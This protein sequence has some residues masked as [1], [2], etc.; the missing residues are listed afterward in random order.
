MP[1][2]ENLCR[3]R[4]PKGEFG[5]YLVAM[6]QQT[7]PANAPA[8][9]RI[10]QAMD[11]PARGHQLGGGCCRRTQGSHEDRRSA[12]S[13]ADPDLTVQV[14]F[15]NLLEAPAMQAGPSFIFGHT[16]QE[17]AMPFRPAL[18]I[19]LA[20]RRSLTGAACYR[21]G[22]GRPEAPNWLGLRRGGLQ[23]Y[24]PETSADVLAASGPVRTIWPIAAGQAMLAGDGRLVAHA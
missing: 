8:G 2:G 21:P 22:A 24:A 3:G 13:T 7:L 17:T 4:S 12:R 1:E 6:A 10:L 5:V 19:A 15:P 16:L 9:M 11:P 18:K 23:R 14:K 20:A